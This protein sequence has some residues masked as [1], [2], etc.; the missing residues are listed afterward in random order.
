M[1]NKSFTILVFCLLSSS[2]LAN[3]L[4]TIIIADTNNSNGGVSFQTDVNKISKIIRKISK[5]IDLTLNLKEISGNKVT[6]DKVMSTI[7]KLS[8]RSNDVVIFYYTGH[9]GRNSGKR[10][11]WPLMDIEGGALAIDWVKSTLKKKNPRFLMILSDTCNNFDNTLNPVWGRS[12]N[13]S[14]SMS[15]SSQNYRRLFLNY[16]GHVFASATE[17]GNF[18]WGNDQYGGFFTDAFLKSLNKELS[19]SGYPNWHAIM[20]RAEAPIKVAGR[21]QQPQSNVSLKGIH[22]GIPDPIPEQCYYFYRPNGVLC[23]KTP[24]GTTCEE[25]S[26]QCPKGGLFMKP[27][28]LTCCRRPTGITCE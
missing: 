10:S 11:L 24:S 15:S 20:K 21:I 12:S 27:G 6:V 16:R 19:T 23:C 18:A 8:V 5:Q 4:H 25:Q 14:R 1:L 13:S 28:G 7:E 2:L 26:Q 3:T 22:A 17:P 9:G